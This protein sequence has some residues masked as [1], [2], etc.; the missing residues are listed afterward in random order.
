MFSIKRAKDGHIL[1]VG[2]LDA[3]Q[4]DRARNYFRSV[5]E[6]CTLDFTDLDYISSAGLGFLLGTQ[7]RLSESGHKL[8]LVNMNKYIRDIFRI[9]G[10][11]NI[12]DIE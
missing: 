12:F 9:A 6:S 4:V 7:K 5:T 2:R 3:A 8:K 11:D 1:L 10:F